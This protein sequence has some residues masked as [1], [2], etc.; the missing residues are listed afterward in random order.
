IAQVIDSYE[1]SKYLHGSS[2]D[3]TASTP[4]PLNP[5]ELK[6]DNIVLYMD[7]CDTLRYS[8]STVGYGASEIR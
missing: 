2:A 6:V 7:S 1:V 4:T 5:E 3:A 8:S